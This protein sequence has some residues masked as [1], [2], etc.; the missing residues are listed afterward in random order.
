M[1]VRGIR[2]PGRANLVVSLVALHQGEWR[3]KRVLDGNA[4]SVISPFFEDR[5]DVGAPKPL[6]DN[7]SWIYQGSIFLGDGF[8]LTHSEAE[9]MV[10]DDPR[11]AAVV[12]R[13]IN[14]QELNSNPDQSPGKC[15]INFF[16]WPLEKAETYGQ[17]FQRVLELVKPARASDKRAVRR[18]RW[19]QYAERATGLYQGLQSIDRC[20]VAAITTK[21]LNFS[22]ISTD[23]V[24]TNA[25]YVFTTDRWDLYTVV[26]S[27]LHEVWAR[28]YSGALETRLRYSPSECF[29]TYPFPEALWQTANPTLAEI[30]E[31]YHEHRRGLM[32]QLWL[33]LTDIYNLFHTRDLMPAVVEKV[34][35]KSPGDAEAGYQGILE[36][37]RLHREL[38]IAI[39]NAN[40]WADFDLG[41]DFHELE[42]LPE[43]D[44]IR[45]TISPAAR[46]E[47]LRRLL[48]LNHQRAAAEVITVPLKKKRG[49]RPIG[50]EVLE[51]LF[52]SSRRP[53]I[54]EIDRK[55]PAPVVPAQLPDGAW[56]RSGTN[57]VADAGAILAAILKAA[58]APESIRKVRLAAILAEEPRLLT[59]TLAA[60]EALLWRR[61]VGADA[62]LIASDVRQFV[63]SAD[64]AWGSAVQQLRGGGMLIEDLAAN[65]WAPGPGLNA[66]HTDGW[67]DGRARMVL[68]VLRRRSADEVI[69]Q[70]PDEIQR[71]VDAQAA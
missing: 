14:G 70:L 30:G 65:T 6:R 35:K 36:L 5:I 45:Y 9:A 68:S 15:A 17:A 59:P 52:D 66:I 25:L 7:A 26:Q 71:W 3:G 29:E 58:G 18:E 69:R 47:V 22:A 48:A 27:T 24:F 62:A 37:R 44:R 53:P 8:L 31:R 63:P 33:G 50:D 20:F 28:K 61:L 46:K 2:W 19:W 57:R 49:K 51:D 56:A 54:P 34:S 10:R 21:H 42:T 16:D 1:A 60:D 40:G 23:M 32:R 55:P 13:T 38:D 12:F 43:N 4:V 67:P 11:L 64:R 41:H 39:R